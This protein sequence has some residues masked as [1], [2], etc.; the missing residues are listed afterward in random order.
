MSGTTKILPVAT[1]AQVRAY[2]RRMTLR[3]PRAL[4]GAL[5]LHALAA[6]AGLV[7]PRLLGELV[8]GVQQGS[9]DVDRVALAIGGFVVAQGVLLRY[10]Y[11]LSTRLGERVLAELREEF[12]DEVVRL[13]LSTVERAGTGDLVTRTS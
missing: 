10:A 5:V 11:F 9:V 6:V 4:T 12:V 3:H 13:P 7:M 2:A 8:E 1:P